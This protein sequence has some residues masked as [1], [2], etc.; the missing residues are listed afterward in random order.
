MNV[1]YFVYVVVDRY[2]R[3]LSTTKPILAK[4]KTSIQ[5]VCESIDLL[6]GLLVG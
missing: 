5:L 3:D 6:F 4:F 2:A 1:C